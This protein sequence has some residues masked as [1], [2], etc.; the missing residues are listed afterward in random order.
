MNK[1]TNLSFSKFSSE[2][3]RI[4]TVHDTETGG[5]DPSGRDANDR[6]SGDRGRLSNASEYSWE[7]YHS[8]TT[9]D[10]SEGRVQAAGITDG[11]SLKPIAKE[12]NGENGGLSAIAPF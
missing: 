1:S 2:L 9:K 5:V 11:A 7:T 6:V 3:S 8:P 4:E 10:V 12:Q